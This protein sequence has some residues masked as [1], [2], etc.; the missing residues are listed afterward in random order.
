[1]NFL[2]PFTCSLWVCVCLQCVRACV[3]VHACLSAYV[4]VHAKVADT[5]T[6]L[7]EF[8]KGE[9]GKAGS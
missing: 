2:S 7:K 8:Y 3:F 1:M 6:S 5:S 4:C 9:I